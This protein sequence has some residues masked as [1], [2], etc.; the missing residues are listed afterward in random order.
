M[1]CTYPHNAL[2]EINPYFYVEEVMNVTDLMSEKK[3]Q[4]TEN[5][6]FYFYSQEQGIA[7][8]INYISSKNN[9]YI[10]TSK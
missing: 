3:T 2:L 1:P 6:K 10:L 8:L 9:V 4:G 7:C 5:H